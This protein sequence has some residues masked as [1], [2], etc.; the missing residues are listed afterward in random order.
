M[1]KIIPALLALALAGIVR[2]QTEFVVN[3]DGIGARAL[4]M[5][6]AQTALTSD[7]GAVYWNPAGLARVRQRELTC[8]FYFLSLENTSSYGGGPGYSSDLSEIRLHSAGYVHPV[9]TS[10]G[11]LVLALGYSKPKNLAYTQKGAEGTY[12]AEGYVSAWNF[13]A[14]LDLSPN[15]SF[16]FNFFI[17]GGSDEAR[18]TLNSRFVD[19]AP[20]DTFTYDMIS[21]IGKFFGYGL[22]LGLLFSLSEHFAA[23]LSA[24][25]LDR[26]SVER[27][28]EAFDGNT[29]TGVS[30]NDFLMNLPYRVA[31]GLAYR[32]VPLNIEVDVTYT[33]WGNSRYTEKGLETPFQ[34]DDLAN[35]LGLSA[36]L[37]YLLPLPFDKMPG[38]RL[39]TGYAHSQIPFIS[40]ES[41]SGRNG[42]S[43]GLGLLFDKS[44]LI[45]AG[46]MYA[47]SETERKNGVKERVSSTTGLLTFS[48]RY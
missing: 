38:I 44:M 1:K 5:A 47:V 37:E 40:Y 39:R 17:N 13:A 20:G 24:H 8:S 28:L 31:A 45:E 35:T 10:Q 15:V 9:P 4:G 16:G 41:K 18:L 2:A 21:D 23:G 25:T 32:T 7:Y 6:G 27:N 30:S 12:S 22:N 36:G 43:G 19:A 3:D 29:L 11:S 48:Y 42:V 34:D 46:G 26:I 14:A 33:L